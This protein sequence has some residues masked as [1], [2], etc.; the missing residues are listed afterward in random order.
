[1][2][3][4]ENTELKAGSEMISQETHTQ[5]LNEMRTSHEQ[6]VDQAVAK[7]S[8]KIRSFEIVDNKTE[9]LKWITIYL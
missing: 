5:L 7:V 3:E 2:L 6:E 9:S 1:M 4:R 8:N